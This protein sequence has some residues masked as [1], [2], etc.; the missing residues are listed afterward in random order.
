M[1]QTI[2]IKFLLTIIVR[3]ALSMYKFVQILSDVTVL[4]IIIC[5]Q[6]MCLLDELFIVM[7]ITYT[8]SYR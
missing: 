3:T 7:L 1:L 6:L 4:I 2:Q 8:H 5:T